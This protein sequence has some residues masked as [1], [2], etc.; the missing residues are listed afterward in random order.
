MATHEIARN[1]SGASG[2]M[3]E[4]TTRLQS[5]SHSIA[6]ALESMTTVATSA[7]DV[8]ES[9]NRSRAS[10]ETLGTVVEQLTS[11]VNEFKI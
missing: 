6:L 5:G 3:T 10:V 1:I 9:V 4:S 7:K 11:I 8:E 2:N